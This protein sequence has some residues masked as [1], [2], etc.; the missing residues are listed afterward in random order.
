MSYRLVDSNALAIKYPEVNDMDCIYA[1]LED[2]LDNKYHTIDNNIDT[3][4]KLLSK[5][6]KEVQLVIDEL[7][8]HISDYTSNDL[9]WLDGFNYGLKAAMNILTERIEFVHSVML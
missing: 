2:G 9:M 4:D 3:K 6:A 1:D 7:K 5:V 8:D